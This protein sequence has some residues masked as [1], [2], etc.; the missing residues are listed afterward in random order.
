MLGCGVLLLLV[1][2]LESV[3]GLVV[4]SVVGVGVSAVGATVTVVT[5][6]VAGTDNGADAGVAVGTGNACADGDAGT[7]GVS[8]GVGAGGDIDPSSDLLP[9]PRAWASTLVLRR[10]RAVFS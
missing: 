9:T 8:A 7:A 1:V 4:F 5:G 3:S 2:R 10:A 6:V